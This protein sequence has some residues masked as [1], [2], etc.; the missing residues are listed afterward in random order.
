MKVNVET[1]LPPRGISADREDVRW[2]TVK[3]VGRVASAVHVG[4]GSVGTELLARPHLDA[5]LD[6]GLPVVASILKGDW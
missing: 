5:Q 6:P 2:V 1:K 4:I 3:C